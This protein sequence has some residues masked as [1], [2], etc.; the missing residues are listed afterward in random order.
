[1]KISILIKSIYL[2]FILAIISCHTSTSP[3][4]KEASEKVIAPMNGDNLKQTPKIPKKKKVSSISAA[5]YHMLRDSQT[6]SFQVNRFPKNYQ[7]M[8]DRYA[9]LNCEDIT[10]PSKLIFDEKFRNNFPQSSIK[11]NLY[12]GKLFCL[13]DL[14]L[15]NKTLG[16][17]LFGR[18]EGGHY[19]DGISIVTSNSKTK[20]IYH[21]NLSSHFGREGFQKTIFSKLDGRTVFRKIEIRYGDSNLHP[22]SLKLQPR[23]VINQA[24]TIDEFGVMSKIHERIEKFNL[25][26]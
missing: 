7:K 2:L 21:L 5:K 20:S 15:K 11:T 6:Y 17:L 10:I 12:D 8:V 4:K 1:M 23:R 13:K 14:N 25:D 19:S 16:K 18:S 22:D 3:E 26:E 24:I 9:K